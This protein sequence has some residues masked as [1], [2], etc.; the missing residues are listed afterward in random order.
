MH[1]GRFILLLLL[2]P[3][4]AAAASDKDVGEY[5]LGAGDLLKI[6]VYGYPDMSADIRVDEAGSITY[7]YVGQLAVGGRSARDVESL[8][9]QKLTSGGFIRSPQVSVLV[10]DYRS[11]A[12]AVMGQVSRPGQYPLRKSSAVSTCWPK[13]AE[14]STRRQPMK[15]RC[16]MRMA[17][18]SRSI[19]LRCSTAIRGRTLRSA[20]ATPSTFRAPRSSTSTAKCRDRAPI[21]WSET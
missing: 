16:F 12:V 19:S 2:A 13:R 10:A 4:L 15:R 7:A 9:A 18:R 14:S 3:V 20:R 17:A 1:L 5:R 11:Q 6:N 8:V 21:A